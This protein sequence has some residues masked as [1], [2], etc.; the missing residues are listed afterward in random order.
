MH[1]VLN[2][3]TKLREIED[4]QRERPTVQG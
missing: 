4:M 2:V 3:G 1:N